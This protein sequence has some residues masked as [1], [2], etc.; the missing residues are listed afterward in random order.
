[1]A[2]SS[3]DDNTGD[4]IQFTSGLDLVGSDK[5]GKLL[6]SYGINDCE[7]ATFFIGMET[8]QEMLIEVEEGLEVVNLME[9]L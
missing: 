2:P 3:D 7:A 8:V 4:V 6:V 9:K 5:N 1:M